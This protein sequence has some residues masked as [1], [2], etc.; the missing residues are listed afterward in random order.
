MADA[1][2]LH[3]A[4]HAKH[5][6]REQ[7]REKAVAG[8]AAAATE[9]SFR[10]SLRPLP[11]IVYDS[12][13]ASSSVELISSTQAPA[14]LGTKT[15]VSSSSSALPGTNI[16]PSPI[17]GAHQDSSRN[18]SSPAGEIA[19]ELWRAGA[20]DR[21]KS[22]GTASAAGRRFPCQYCSKVYANQVGSPSLELAACFD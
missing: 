1:G 12:F 2:A 6:F 17:V 11:P 20:H 10:S 14:P 5:A 4:D 22:G 15:N 19:P 7:A 8:D 13:R 3:R 9:S 18:L 16:S 21:K